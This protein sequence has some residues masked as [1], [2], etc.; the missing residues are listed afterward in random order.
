[1][2]TNTNNNSKNV[3][4]DA[5]VSGQSIK[6]KVKSKKITASDGLELLIF[7]AE[8]RNGPAG[9]AVFKTSHTYNWL[10]RRM[11]GRIGGDTTTSG[12]KSIL[13]STSKNKYKQGHKQKANQAK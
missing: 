7:E 2:K 1:M 13:V 8:K 10:K 9:V 5:S 6:E 12:S 3:G 11:F 4:F